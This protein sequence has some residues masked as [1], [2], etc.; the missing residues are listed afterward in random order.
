MTTVASVFTTHNRL[1]I[2]TC[3]VDCFITL[4]ALNNIKLDYFAVAYTRYSLSGIASGDGCTMH[5]DVFLAVIARDEA[6][7]PLDVEPDYGS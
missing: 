6:K 7:S 5:K 4:L 2:G 1:A 3:Y